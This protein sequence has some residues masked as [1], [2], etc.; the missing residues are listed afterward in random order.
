[1]NSKVDTGFCLSYW[2]LSYRRKFLRTIWT[3]M[4]IPLFFLYPSSKVF[5]G[6]IPRNTFVLVFFVM[7]LLQSVYNYARWKRETPESSAA[8]NSHG[9]GTLP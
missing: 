6:H 2:S 4:L 5:F 8:P 9:P 7:W 1:M 3:G